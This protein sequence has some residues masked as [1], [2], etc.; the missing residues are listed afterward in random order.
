MLAREQGDE[1]VAQA[2]LRR[3][4]QDFGRVETNGAVS[5]AKASN[6]NNATIIMGRLARQ[7]DMRNTVLNGPP[8]TALAGPVLAEVAYP[9]VLVAKA[10][11][12]DGKSLE[13]VLYP[14]R[15]EGKQTLHLAR[16]IPGGRYSAGGETFAADADGKASFE[17]LLSGR[18][19][20]TI[21][22]EG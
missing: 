2:I 16:L 3:L 10:Y 13:L 20:V 12:H 9:D 14:G 21:T 7:A 1:Q 5:Y 19:A 15:A 4:D 18:T 11:S 22:P 17:C 6:V 8:A